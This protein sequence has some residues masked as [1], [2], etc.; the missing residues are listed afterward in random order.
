MGRADPA[1][2]AHGCDLVRVHDLAG[3][4][5][6]V[7]FAADHQGTVITSHESVD[8]LTRL[9]LH[10]P[11]ERTWLA[12]AEAIT[13]LPEAGLALVRTEGLGLRPVPV[14]ARGRI[15]PGADL[16]LPADGWHHARA[17]GAVQVT[18]T[19][20]DRFHLIDEAVELAV[21]AQAAEALRLGGEA[22]GGPVIDAA[23]GAVL[24]VL[25]T[26]LQAGR[27]A[28]VFALPLRV[29]GLPEGPLAALLRHNAATVP[30]YGDDLNLATVLELTATSLGPCARPGQPF[31]GPGI[32]RRLTAPGPP[33]LA[34]V[35]DPGT[36]RTTALAALA[37][38]RAHGPEPAPTVWLRGADLHSEDASVADA[39]ARALRRAGR[40]LAASGAS[41]ELSGITPERVAHLARLA[42]RP[43]LVV[44]DGPEEMP[45]GLAR[46]LPSWT[47]GTAH[48]LATRSARMALGCRPEHWEYALPLHPAGPPPP[49]TVRLAE[50]S[51]AEAA[52]A[53]E[54][55]GLPA[56]PIA[57]PHEGHPL[58]LGALAEVRG[59][60]PFGVAGR[61]GREEVFG[62]HLDLVC[63]RIAVRVA[64]AARPP[65]RGPAV[66]RLA[67]RVAGRVHEA[68]RRCLG[69]GHGE[70]DRESF[71]E[72][73]PWRPGWAAAVLT[74]GLLVP[75]GE[76]YRFAHEEVGEWLQGARLDPDEALRTLVHRPPA[77]APARLPSRPGR[78]LT[79]GHVP[80]PPGSARHRP[81]PP[82]PVPRHRIGPV[83]HSLLRLDRVHGPAALTR[84]LK[85]LIDAVIRPEAGADAYWWAA[86]L[87]AGTLLR[88]PA[89]E[90]QLPML[91]LLARRLARSARRGVRPPAEF[92]PDFWLRLRLPEPARLDLLRL[93]LPAD[94]PLG[95][96]PTAPAASVPPGT[97]VPVP[98]PVSP[99]AVA[100]VSP[101]TPGPVPAPSD[102]ATASPSASRPAGSP[103]G[104]AQGASMLP[105]AGPPDALGR[106]PATAVR[107]WAEMPGHGQPPGPE[108]RAWAAPEDSAYDP[109]PPPAGTSQRYL[110]AVA[111]RLEADP[112]TVQ[113][114][115]CRW[116]TD[117]TPLPTHPGDRMR[118]T[119]GAV[120]QALLYARRALALDD[121]AEA[122]AESGHARADE[123]LAALA[124]EEP[125]ALCRAVD[126]W[127]HDPRP[128]RRAAAAAYALPVAARVTSEA[129]RRLLRYAA[130]ELLGRP[131]DAASHG[132]ALAVLV[133][134]PHARS[135]VLRRALASYA[136]AIPGLSASA[137]AT[138]LVTHPEPVFA[139][140]RSR[141]R[142]DDRAGEVLT[143]LAGATVPALARRAAALV[144]EYLELHPGGAA[145]AAVF[146]DRRLDHG[147][148]ARSLLFPLVSTALREGPGRLRQALAPVLAAPG[149]ALSRPLRAELLDVLLAACPP[150]EHETATALLKAAAL[151]RAAR[152][153]A[154][155][156]ELVRRAGLLLTAAP[157]GAVRFERQLL[158]LARAAPGFAELLAGWLAGP[159]QDWSAPIGPEAR[160]TIGSL[161]SPTPMRSDGPGHGSLRPA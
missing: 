146:V 80:P 157:G 148:A 134:D 159:P 129:D 39:V 31:P 44:V 152:P 14:T 41:G 10:A 16:R 95:P 73:F 26:A 43:L 145:Y 53:P 59:G 155:T 82:L 50:L 54:R 21:P 106:C 33:V 85:D 86:R 111:A 94:G 103:P 20:T 93:L 102:P 60:L 23:T 36:G 91:R 160:R 5:R 75:A 32:L 136:A 99:P 119:A 62:A 76:G 98:S 51:P 118:P 1:T 90:S 57:P 104:T 45:P 113:P 123:L 92:G 69:P 78:T 116:F 77:H 139:A 15:V 19:A 40:V 8:G 29:H 133:Q 30:G 72:L 117:N 128:G 105:Q 126:R 101:G 12:G 68:A 2:L 63:L 121:L 55:H 17:L 24:A 142:A 38:H 3:R 47:A 140:F 42:G 48:W 120:A 9:V 35:G 13:P 143:A 97:P 65:L 70:L 130:H 132:T 109:E 124:D 6:G 138:A 7:G 4:P 149:N 84:R 27:R 46:R 137:L 83:V 52:A 67:A 107:P 71:E 28:A 18:Y 11:G 158:R 74:E 125:S 115:L 61:P 56:G 66:R 100:S 64:A 87:L 151:G 58:A 144:A 96:P 34:L 112:A 108:G 150:Y 88:L 25:G 79:P 154:A 131:D 49:R 156:R 81:P 122:L 89:P 114:L 161:G 37:A 153:E 147:P 110:D 135:R 141:L 127:A 22:S